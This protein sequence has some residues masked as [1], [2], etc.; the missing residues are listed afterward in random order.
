M[1]THNR[2]KKTSIAH[3][4]AMS[5]RL[6]NIAESESWLLLFFIARSR[7]LQSG[8]CIFRNATWRLSEI[9]QLTGAA[10]DFSG[11]FLLINFAQQMRHVKHG[12]K[13]GSNRMTSYH[14]LFS[15]VPSTIFA[16]PN[17]RLQ[18]RNPHTSGSIQ[19]THTSLSPA[20]PSTLPLPSMLILNSTCNPTNPSIFMHFA[21]S[22]TLNARTP[23]PLHLSNL[24]KLSAA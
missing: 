12:S 8:L 15:A 10:F 9:S 24:C 11:G 2:N 21:T 17:S 18:A 16:N 23:P 20:L 22:L 6:P 7:R 3:M 19:R 1:A 13:N 5:C 4:S 14:A